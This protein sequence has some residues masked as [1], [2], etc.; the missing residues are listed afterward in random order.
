MAGTYNIE[1]DAGATY[2]RAIRWTDSA[3]A[4]IVLTGCTA[5]MMARTAYSD[6]NTTI[7]LVSP[8]AGLA[9]ANATNGTIQL[10]LDAATTANLVSGVYDLEVAFADG[11]VTRLLSGSLTVSPEVTHA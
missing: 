2:S 1:I 4:P 9:I 5:R 6:A 11:T 3:N 10:T 8:S 7:S